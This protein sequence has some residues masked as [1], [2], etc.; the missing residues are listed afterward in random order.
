MTLQS[1]QIKATI[2]LKVQKPRDASDLVSKSD[3]KLICES[4]LIST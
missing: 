4:Q 1:T 3:I 2:T